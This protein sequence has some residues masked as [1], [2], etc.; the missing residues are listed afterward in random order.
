MLLHNVAINKLTT[1]DYLVIKKEH[2]E[3]E[4]YLIDLHDA[5]ACSDLNYR[6]CAQA[7][8][9]SCLG[10][11]P[12]FLFHIIELAEKHFDHEDKIMLSRPQIT[13]ECEYFSYHHQAHVNLMLRLQALSYEYLSMKNENYIAKIYRH[14]YEK[15]TDMFEEHDRLF[16]NPFIESTRGVV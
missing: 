16:D 4:K 3:L 13:N 5:C 7:N 12:S 6:T 15:I 8:Q 2:M 10:R 11:L 1:V 14:F 9:A